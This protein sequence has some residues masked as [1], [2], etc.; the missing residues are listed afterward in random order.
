MSIKSLAD[1][2]YLVRSTITINGKRK[3]RK[4]VCNT[5]QEALFWKSK[6]SKELLEQRKLN[7]I[8]EPR[9]WRNCLEE[10]L[11]FAKDHLSTATL[12]NRRMCLMSLS[13]DWMSKDIEAITTSEIDQVVNNQG[14]SVAY[15]KDALKFIRAVYEFNIGTRKTN[16]NPC[17]LIKV[18]FDKSE[19]NEAKVLKA[20][21][22][23]EVQRLLLYVK[24]NDENWYHIFAVTYYLGLRYS[25]AI[26]LRAG[27][28]DFNRKIATISRSWCKKKRGP[29]PPKNGFSRK[30]PISPF[31]EGILKELIA[32]NI[33]GDYVLPRVR[34]WM[35][36]MGAKCL[37]Q[38]QKDL[39][40][41]KSNY[42]SLRASFI[43]HLLN[44]GVP[45]VKVQAM[46]GHSDLKTTQRYIRLDATDLDGA[47]DVLDLGYVR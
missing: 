3:E 21:T 25:E 2:K 24:E 11:D 32:N 40:I 44:R 15:R 9:C 12:Y 27:D 19:L 4:R 22:A 16:F 34:M 28:I 26:E 36:M 13:K 1:G 31:L 37:N 45:L 10:Y 42:H 20:M 5:R 8:T 39:G 38:F 18:K 6:L 14:F 43:T 17:K 29:V 33:H 41:R 47:T 46:V 7:E 30:I 23:D 35:Q